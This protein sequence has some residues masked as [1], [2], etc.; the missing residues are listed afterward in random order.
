MAGWKK[1]SLLHRSLEESAVYLSSNG[2]A[3]A[4][5]QR[6]DMPTHIRPSVIQIYSI[7]MARYNKPPNGNTKKVIS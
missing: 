2:S 6:R 1:P 7:S 5:L 3:A 4:R